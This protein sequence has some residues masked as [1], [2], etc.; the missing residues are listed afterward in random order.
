MEH[1][2]SGE[3]I[4]ISSAGLDPAAACFAALGIRKTAWANMELKSI[5]FSKRE[6]FNDSDDE[7]D[8]DERELLAPITKVM[9]ANLAGHFKFTLDESIWCSP[10]VYGGFTP[11]GSVVGVLCG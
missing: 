9:A 1:E 5:D 7:F 6:C 10:V 8:E 2:S 4:I 3:V 11:Q